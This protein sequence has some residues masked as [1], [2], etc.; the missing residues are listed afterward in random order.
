M[1][2]WI[3]L[4]FFLLWPTLLF[5]Q[6][7]LSLT[8]PDSDL[9]VIYLSN[10]FGVVDG[11]LFGTGSQLLGELFGI[12]N[13]AVLI[14]GGIVVIYTFFIGTLKTAHEGEVLGREWSSIFIPLRVV[15]GITLLIP[16]K[17]GYSF[18]QI[19]MMWVIIQGVGLADSVWN[20]ALKYLYSGG[21]IISQN[22]SSSG[23]KVSNYPMI[24]LSAKLLRSLTCVEMLRSELIRYRTFQIQ[25][26]LPA[27][28][29]VPDFGGDI[30]NA[31]NSP[32]AVTL[33]NGKNRVNFPTSNYYNTNGV[34]GSASWQDVWTN[35]PAQLANNQQ[36]LATWQGDKTRSTAVS[37]AVTA[38]LPAAK[39]IANNYINRSID[40]KTATPLG[41]MIGKKWT[42][43]N[44]GPFL[45]KGSILGDSASAYYGTMA[46][47]MRL[48]SQSA[49]SAAYSST[50]IQE[51][52]KKGWALAGAYYF[53][54]VN[55]NA[56][57]SDIT[58][59]NIPDITE[60]P[61]DITLEDK[62]TSILGGK[63]SM[64]VI[65]MQTLLNGNN[66]STS[67]SAPPNNYIVSISSPFIAG[68][69][70]YASGLSYGSTA[71]SNPQA[72]QA[73]APA[74]G[75]SNGIGGFLS[76]LANSQSTN[77]NPVIEI[78]KFGNSLV[79]GGFIAI[80]L[81]S[82]IGFAATI[83]LGAIPFCSVG[84]AGV[85]IVTAMTS[86]F[87][88]IFVTLIAVGLTM[89]YYIPMIPF[90]IFS[91]GVVGWF[92]SVVEAM[93]AAPIVALGVSHPEGSHAVL[94]KA[95]P[96][97]GLMVSVFLRP[98][99]MIFGLLFGMMVSYVGLWL[100]NQ[101]FGEAFNE[102]TQQV[103]GGI[104]K[105][106]ISIIIYVMIVMQIVQKSFSLIHIIPDQTLRWIGIN[107]QGMGGEAEAEQ[108]IGGS[109]KAGMGKLAKSAGSKV[110]ASTGAGKGA[111]GV[112]KG[113]KEK[114]GKGDDKPNSLQ[115]DASKGG[116]DTPSVGAGN[117]AG[118][119]GAGGG[120]A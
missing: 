92:I 117:D 58:D 33:S 12:F 32:T 8:P 108:A 24:A 107:V 83:G 21:I 80:L 65:Q 116:G 89:S 72:A 44:N 30:L 86:M 22:Y 71:L 4:G 118:G 23:G 76:G 99:F 19:F 7:S 104:F 103:G 57:V 3:F 101:G 63:S 17:T 10:M 31:I 2:R 43:P 54:I 105:P 6:S 46:A 111:G 35:L 77:A 53:N 14:L 59:G 91:F 18:I 27:I 34:C 69:V 109:A 110:G 73:T 93:L 13:G 26:G 15:F 67:S 56:Q 38:L 119:G 88:P 52:E 115:S 112:A 5:A 55:A 79:I 97:V 48:I 47:T 29:P 90:I 68:A 75:V 49:N 96:A 1:K 28:D 51:A 37:Q 36:F 98:T 45:I 11:V 62:I 81:L 87:T 9:S 106:I 100:L 120:A 113:Q 50:W 40:P 16:K 66:T 74:A 39:S 95:D 82:I 114:E 102:A 94:G 60:A 78:A 84:A 20:A 25:K 61:F 64:Y 85:S 41:L 70:K 42:G